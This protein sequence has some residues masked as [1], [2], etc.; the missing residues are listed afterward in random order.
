MLAESLWQY[1]EDELAETA[2]RLT[3]DELHEVQLISVW[4]HL[5]DV[6][7]DGGPKLTNARIMARAMIEFVERNDRDTS[8]RRRR[9]R[10]EADAYSSGLPDTPAET[11][12]DLHN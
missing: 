11:G 4:H 8:R 5:N 9:T 12:L 10:P 1:G 3:D 2:L 6:D 7:P